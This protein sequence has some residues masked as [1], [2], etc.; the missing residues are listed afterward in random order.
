MKRGY[1]RLLIFELIIYFILTIN[2]FFWNLLGSYITVIFLFISIIILKKFFGLERDKHRHT[3]EI[4][5][6]III[7]LI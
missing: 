3:Q 4:I 7:F 6:D 1:K 5:L 2:S